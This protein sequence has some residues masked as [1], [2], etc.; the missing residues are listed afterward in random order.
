VKLA[1]GTVGTIF[2]LLFGAVTGFGLWSW[3]TACHPAPAGFGAPILREVCSHMLR[4]SLAALGLSV[5][6]GMAAYLLIRYRGR[7]WIRRRTV[8][9]R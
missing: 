3:W 7:T 9:A 5:L 6:T 4:D 1:F 2:S 8:S